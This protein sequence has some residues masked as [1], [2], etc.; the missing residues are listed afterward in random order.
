MR[1]TEVETTHRAKVPVIEANN[2]RSTHMNNLLELEW[3]ETPTRLIGI[4]SD[5]WE[6]LQAEL[7]SDPPCRCEDCRRMPWN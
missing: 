4:A 3:R 2:E 1:E 5:V 6:E 7:E